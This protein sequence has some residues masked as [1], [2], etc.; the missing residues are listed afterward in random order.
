MARAR[1]SGGFD[2][3]VIRLHRGLRVRV[4]LG[5][6]LFWRRS[7]SPGDRL[8]SWVSK[9]TFERRRRAARSDQDSDG[10]NK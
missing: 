8:L 3:T 2:Q 7:W 6:F 9:A 5:G 10:T 4:I 1:S